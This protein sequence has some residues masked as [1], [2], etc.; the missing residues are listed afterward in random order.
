M[1]IKA[2]IERIT[3]HVD[4]QADLIEQILLA[5]QSKT[6]GGDGGEVDTTSALDSAVLGEMI[7]L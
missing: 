3:G 5:L 6:S 1:S 2:Q 4:I 7:L